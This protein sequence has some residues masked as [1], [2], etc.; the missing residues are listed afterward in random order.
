MQLKFFYC[1]NC[2]K[3]IAIV[4]DSGVQTFCC[5]EAMIELL[6]QNDDETLSEKHVPIIKVEGNTVSVTVGAK[7]HPS[8]VS[9]FIEWILLQT[10]KGIQQKWLNPGNSPNVEFAIMTGEKVE[11][12]YDYCNI[13]NLW[14][15]K[16]KPIFQ[17]KL[18]LA[19]EQN[20]GQIGGCC[21]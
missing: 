9:H 3:I 14:K 20:Y 10:D 5:G 8:E 4:K 11:A 12:A 1:K 6:P 13:H 18:T 2:G 19:K 17:P 15:S 7:S 21:E 16:G